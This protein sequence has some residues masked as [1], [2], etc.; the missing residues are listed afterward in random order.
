M[1][2]IVKTY[3]SALIGYFSPPITKTISGKSYK[4][5]QS[6][7]T[8]MEF[9]NLSKGFDGPVKR[10]VPVSATTLHPLNGSQSPR[11]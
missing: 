8:S 6:S 9:N 11:S 2:S 5:E 7:S 10:E 3:S 1:E 4:L